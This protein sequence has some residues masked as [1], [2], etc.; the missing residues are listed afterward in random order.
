MKSSLGAINNTLS[1]IE[2]N[3]GL[4]KDGM[5]KV[6]DYVSS[7]KADTDKKVNLVGT[8]VEVEGHILKVNIAMNAIQR[9]LDLLINRVINAQK[10]VLQPKIISPSTLIEALLKGAPA[11]PKDTT[12]PIPLSKYS[13]HQLMRLCDLQVH[14]KHGILSYVTLTPLVN[15]G[16]FSIY[17]LIPIPVALDRTKFLYDTGKSFL[18]IDQA[19]QYYFLS[20][21]EG[22]ENCKTLNTSFKV[23]KQNQPL[24]SSHLHENCLVKMLQPRGSVPTMCERIVELFNPIWTQLENNK[25]IH[26]VPTSETITILCSERHP[27]DI[28]VTEIGNLGLRED[29]KG[30]GRSA[31]FQ[32]HSIL[33]VNSPGLESDFVKCRFALQL[34]RT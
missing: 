6:S 34:L 23:C 21:K 5:M 22:M 18:W 3:E 15:R 27:M 14:I 26:F 19:R 29:C 7:L 24:L 28:N 31:H 25:W 20:D 2:Y 11:F 1:D 33:N 8:K 9:K 4:I 12:L 10:G 17:R 13:A 32:T 16:E 30:F